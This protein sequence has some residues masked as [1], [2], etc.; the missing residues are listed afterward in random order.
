MA[1]DRMCYIVKMEE[2]L[3]ERS[4][5]M[6]VVNSKCKINHASRHLL[7]MEKEIKFCLDDLWNSNYLSEDDYK[8][9]KPSASEPGVMYGL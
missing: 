1:I 5:F 9:M 6:K 7:D 4:K 8:F 2:L 3:I